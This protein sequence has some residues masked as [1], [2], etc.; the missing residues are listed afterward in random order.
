MF[1]A[2][3]P[4]LL[5]YIISILSICCVPCIVPGTEHARVVLLDQFLR[6]LTRCE[7]VVTTSS[8]QQKQSKHKYSCFWP[9]QLRP[10]QKP[11][12]QLCQRH[13]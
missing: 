5:Y 13:Q 8:S 2:M 4:I 1:C 7:A 10:C 11:Q 12:M 3:G 9:R 6:M